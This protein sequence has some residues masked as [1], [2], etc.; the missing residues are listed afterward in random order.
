[1]PGP[2][3][4]CRLAGVSS[5][6]VRVS[7]PWPST[8]AEAA[9]REFGGLMGDCVS[10]SQRPSTGLGVYWAKLRCEA[11]PGSP[12]WIASDVLMWSDSMALGAGL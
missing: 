8:P 3:V 4:D 10:G 1:M 5:M 11:G 9:L 6:G 2:Q 12:R 7:V